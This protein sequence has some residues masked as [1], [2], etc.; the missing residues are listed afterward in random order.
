MAKSSDWTTKRVIRS[1]ALLHPDGRVALGLWLDDGTA[2]AIEM[3]KK[4]LDI[5]KK[6]VAQM[7]T[8]L[9]KPTGSA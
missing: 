7:E 3:N 2:F 9:K 6:Q 1:Q 8:Y 4:I 5:L